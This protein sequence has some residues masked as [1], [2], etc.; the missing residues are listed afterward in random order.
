MRARIVKY[1]Y[2]INTTKKVGNIKRF[3][4]RLMD[5]DVVTK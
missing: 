5:I 3:I 4:L 2:L 1:I